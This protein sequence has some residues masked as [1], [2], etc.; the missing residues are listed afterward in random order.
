MNCPNGFL[1]WHVTLQGCDT[2][3]L[4]FHMQ[5]WFRTDSDSAPHLSGQF[6][7]E[8][9][10]T[11]C[12]LL[13]LRNQGEIETKC[14]LRACESFYRQAAGMHVHWSMPFET[15][16]LLYVFQNSWCM[17]LVVR[18]VLWYI[19]LTH[20]QWNWVNC[21]GMLTYLGARILS[22]GMACC[23]GRKALEMKGRLQLQEEKTLIHPRHLWKRLSQSIHFVCQVPQSWLSHADDK[24]ESLLPLVGSQRTHDLS[25]IPSQLNTPPPFRV[26][27]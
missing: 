3:F 8:A 6:G 7:A 1:V 19:P 26:R 23:G 16:L 11:A 27:L 20:G 9:H 21:A 13:E 14:C 12:G 2:F 15:P 17:T 18:I 24:R 5:F 22:M 10:R 25:R 4:L